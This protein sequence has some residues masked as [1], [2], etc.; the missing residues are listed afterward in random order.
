M[1]SIIIPTYNEKE[2]VYE[3]TRL[4]DSNLR[5]RPYEI[6]FVDDSDDETPALLAK[7]AETN[8]K[9]QFIHRDDEKGLA[10]AVVNGFNIARGDILAV[11]DS[12]LQHPAENLLALLEAINAGADIAIA[13]RFIPGGGDGGLNLLRKLISLVARRLAIISLRKLRSV[14]DS[15]SGFFMMR[16]T[17]LNESNLQPIGWKILIEIL[18]R[19]SYKR[20]IEI[21]YRFQSR[22]LGDSKMS[23]R[24]QWNYLLHLARLIKDSPADRR[25]YSF[26]LVGL[27][28][29]IVNMVVY[30]L[31]VYAQIYVVA[32]GAIAA[33]MAMI[34]NFLLND[35][36]TWPEVRSHSMIT[37]GLRFMITSLIGIIIN[38]AL[39]AFLYHRLGINYIAANFIGISAG[40]LWNYTINNCWTWHYSGREQVSYKIDRW[41][42]E[43]VEDIIKEEMA[44]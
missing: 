16:K 1:L 26:A 25:F 41:G 20:I 15:T 37:R 38:V 43:K 8:K 17:V 28:G 29:V 22:R 12:D 31:L 39:L 44:S 27:S 23:A 42:W 3:I 34:S 14:S 32:A 10:T 19:G 11:M 18:A 2:N 21:P 4:I 30:T 9:V 7:L 24:E 36:F 5:N 35:R 6:I 33:S 13:S 40:V